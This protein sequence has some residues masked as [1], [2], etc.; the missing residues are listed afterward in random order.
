MLLKIGIK[1]KFK[2]WILNPNKKQTHTYRTVRE[3]VNSNIKDGSNYFV[4][5]VWE[6]ETKANNTQFL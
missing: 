6:K 3:L 1:L 5:I 4:A 2:N